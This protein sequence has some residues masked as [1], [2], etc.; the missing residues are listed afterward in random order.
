V[1]T[2][3]QIRRGR[4]LLGWTRY[5]LAPRAGMGHTLLAQFENCVRPLDEE[6]ASRLRAALED[7]GVEF[8]FNG[9][10]EAVRLRA[11]NGASVEVTTLLKAK[12]KGEKPK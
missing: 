5:R 11:H 10:G 1:I 6:S 9:S 7:E 2:G 8:L 12:A 3:E 4:E